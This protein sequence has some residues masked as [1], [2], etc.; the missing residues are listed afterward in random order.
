MGEAIKKFQKHAK[1]LQKD[2]GKPLS[3]EERRALHLI[4]KEAREKGTKLKSG[5]KGGLP[6]SFVL[7]VMRR[8]DFKC[9]V[10]GD[11]GEGEHGGIEVHHKGGIVE[12]KWLSKKGHKLEVNNVVTICAKGHDEIHNKARKEGVDSSQVTPEGDK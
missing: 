3:A 8:D 12:S 2:K 6:P 4:R 9:K 11:R 1:K 10:H 7:T 5:G